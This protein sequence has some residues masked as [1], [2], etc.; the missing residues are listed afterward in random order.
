MHFSPHRGC[1]ICRQAHDEFLIVANS[2]RFS[3]HF[4]TKLFFAMV[5]YDE[6][7]DI[8]QQLGINSA[9]VF[10]YFSE[11]GKIKVRT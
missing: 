5:D 1:S 6:G 9:P 4:S 8:F 10:L 11:K 2:W 3:P 7:S